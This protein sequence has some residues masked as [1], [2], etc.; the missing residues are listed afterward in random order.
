MQWSPHTVS[1]TNILFM[2]YLSSF[3]LRCGLSSCNDRALKANC[4]ASCL[5]FF[6]Y[7]IFHILSILLLVSCYMIRLF[8]LPTGSEG[9]LSSWFVSTSTWYRFAR[10]S[11]GEKW[12][13]PSASKISSM[14]VTCHLMV[15][16]CGTST[17]TFRSTCAQR[18]KSNSSGWHTLQG[19]PILPH[20][21][22]Y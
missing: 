10:S 12:K 17:P 2:L 7:S 5:D 15:I 20:H 13:C 8:S 4:Q 1:Y 18:T 16:T 3:L 11:I 9:W 6:I 14:K 21:V 19:V 22:I